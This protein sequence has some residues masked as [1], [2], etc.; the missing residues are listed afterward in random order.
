MC[1]LLICCEGNEGRLREEG[2]YV[3]RNA[4]KASSGIQVDAQ[5]RQQRVRQ[6][7]AASGL[8]GYKQVSYSEYDNTVGNPCASNNM[9]MDLR[10]RYPDIKYM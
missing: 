4:W 2:C 6:P 3:A 7:M 1:I 8:G 9:P 10:V 5:R